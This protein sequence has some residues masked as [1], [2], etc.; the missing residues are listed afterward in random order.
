MCKDGSKKIPENEI[1]A[2]IVAESSPASLA[3][4]DARSILLERFPLV[5]HE[6]KIVRL[7]TTMK[8]LVSI[9]CIKKVLFLN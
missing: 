3:I 8:V 1:T 7:N 5:N 4:C 9:S 2:P 6:P